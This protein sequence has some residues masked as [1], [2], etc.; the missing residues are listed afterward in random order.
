MNEF[1]DWNVK[2]NALWPRSAPAKHINTM[3]NSVSRIALKHVSDAVTFHERS[4]NR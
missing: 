4:T 2:Q 1:A 3:I